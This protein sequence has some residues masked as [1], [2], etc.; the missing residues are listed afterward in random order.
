MLFSTL[1]TFE[2][3]GTFDLIQILVDKVSSSD[4]QALSINVTKQEA[5]EDSLDWLQCITVTNMMTLLTHS[6]QNWHNS[7]V[8]VSL[9]N[10]SGKILSL[11]STVFEKLVLRPDMEHL[12]I[13]GMHIASMDHTLH[14]LQEVGN[15]QLEFLLLPIHCSTAGISLAELRL[16]AEACPRLRF[17]RCPFK[18]LSNVKASDPLSHPLEVLLVNDAEGQIGGNSNAIREIAHYLD[19]I[20][21]NLVSIGTYRNAEELQHWRSIFDLVKLC[22][23]VRIEEHQRLQVNGM[24][25]NAM[26]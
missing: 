8:S 18:N 11:P 12:E 10:D 9:T 17:V 26:N 15:S 22:Q 23:A 20:F 25:S 14:R 5:E 3:D 1:Q 19:S 13:S 4:L 21:P 6:I 7:L 24:Q 2:V 16:I